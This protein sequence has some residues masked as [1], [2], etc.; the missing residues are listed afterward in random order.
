MSYETWKAEF[1][2]ETAEAIVDRGA[3]PIELIE[4]SIRKWEGLKPENLSKHDVIHRNGKLYDDSDPF[5]DAL[6][7]DFSSCSLCQRFLKNSI[8]SACPLHQSR[9]HI[10]CDEPKED[11]RL[12]PY[13]DFVDEGDPLPMIAEL[14]AA[15]EFCVSGHFEI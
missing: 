2:P 8:C 10:D 11:E 13:Y 15:K 5:L 9:G 14:H 12:A 4:H 1:Y 7:I 6:R 3:S